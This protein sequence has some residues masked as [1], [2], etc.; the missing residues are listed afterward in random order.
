MTSLSCSGIPKPASRVAAVRSTAATTLKILT[1]SFDCF[2]RAGHRALVEAVNI[3][4][5]LQRMSFGTNLSKRVAV[6]SDDEDFEYV[7]H[8]PLNSNRSMRITRQSINVFEKQ[9]RIE[10]F[11][12]FDKGAEGQSSASLFPKVVSCHILL[13]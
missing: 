2:A 12:L 10:S 9:S 13:L 7:N 4:S 3:N 11:K 6:T 8:G 5:T 1:R